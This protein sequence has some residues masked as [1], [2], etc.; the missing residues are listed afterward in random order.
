MP[1]G[2]AGERRANEAVAA[3]RGAVPQAEVQQEFLDRLREAKLDPD[4]PDVK[5]WVDLVRAV[6]GLPRHLGQPSGGLVLA[7]GRLDERKV[8]D[9]AR[10]W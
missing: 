5:H 10:C 6:Q 4:S 7:A 2:S 9:A 8:G 1:R 3:A